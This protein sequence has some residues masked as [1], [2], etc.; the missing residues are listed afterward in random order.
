MAGDAARPRLASQTRAA[1][2]RAVLAHPPAS[3]PCK[4]GPIA[5]PVGP[6]LPT[7]FRHTLAPTSEETDPTARR[8]DDDSPEPPESTQASQAAPP[9]PVRLSPKR[10]TARVLRRDLDRLGLLQGERLKASTPG[11]RALPNRSREIAAH[12]AR[13]R[14]QGLVPA[15]EEVEAIPPATRAP[16]LSHPLASTARSAQLRPGRRPTN[17]REGWPISAPVWAF[18]LRTCQLSCSEQTPS[19]LPSQVHLRRGSPASVILENPAFGQ[20]PERAFPSTESAELG[21]RPPRRTECARRSAGAA[22]PGAS[23]EAPG[24]LPQ[25]GRL[26]A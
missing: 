26:S 6:E 16:T 21:P 7:S 23:R 22:L 18:S 3:I 20:T 4:E 5:P 11:N 13:L 14:H 24:V 2:L 1:R 15:S 10:A 17:P 25:G 8:R 12:D 19:R 9:A